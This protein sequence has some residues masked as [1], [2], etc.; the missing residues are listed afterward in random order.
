MPVTHWAKKGGCHQAKEIYKVLAHSFHVLLSGRFL[1]LCCGPGPEGLAL[2]VSLVPQAGAMKE[3]KCVKLTLLRHL[4]HSQTLPGFWSLGP[5][6]QAQVRYGQTAPDGCS[7]RKL[8]W[9]K[10]GTRPF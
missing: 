1:I 5:E 2:W 3:A 7:W 4:P 8:A 10:S 9:L 6:T